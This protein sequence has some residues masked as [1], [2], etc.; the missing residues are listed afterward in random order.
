VKYTYLTRWNTPEVLQNG[1]MAGA[2]FETFVISEIYI[3][4]SVRFTW[5]GYEI[6]TPHH[7]SFS[8]PDI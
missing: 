5:I 3:K 1:A 8:A 2:F 6:Q 7:L 4:A